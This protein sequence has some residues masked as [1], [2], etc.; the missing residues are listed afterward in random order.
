[1]K[2]I[3]HIMIYAFFAIT[4]ICLPFEEVCYGC[5]CGTD[6]ESYTLELASRD[7]IVCTGRVIEKQTGLIGFTVTV[8][9]I[10]EKLHPNIL[11]LQAIQT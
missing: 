9:S 6:A 2:Y 10:V 7:G 5:D 4:I 1:M 8:D 11:G 3:L